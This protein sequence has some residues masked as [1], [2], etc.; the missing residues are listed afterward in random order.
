MKEVT[1]KCDY[2]KAIIKENDPN[3]IVNGKGYI[4]ILLTDKPHPSSKIHRRNAILKIKLRDTADKNLER[5]IC[6]NC[7]K[8]C[9]K[10]K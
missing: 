3:T 5:D 7:L 9:L 1:V 10:V 2:C 8:K 4:N 6:P